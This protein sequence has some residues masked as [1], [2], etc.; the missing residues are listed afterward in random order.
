MDYEV[1][2]TFAFTVAH[3]HVGE[4]LPFQVVV[5]SLAHKSSRPITLSHFQ[6][7]FEGGLRNVDIRHDDHINRQWSTEDELVLFFAPLLQ[8]EDSGFLQG[9]CNLEIAPGTTKVFSLAALPLDAGKIE[10]SK[11]TL[12]VEAEQFG[13][14]LAMSGDNCL[15]QNEVWA[16]DWKGLFRG[17]ILS[18]RSTT[19]EVLPKP[20]KIRIELP[21]IMK[22]YFTGE[23]VSIEV[24][25]IND[26]EEECSVDLEMVLL[27]QADSAPVLHWA[28]TSESTEHA[29]EQNQKSSL[30]TSLGTMNPL[31]TR[32]LTA[33]FQARSE[34]AEGTLEIQAR[35]FLSSDPDTPVSKAISI[36][37]H[38]MRPL[39]A[40]FNFVPQ[41]R[42]E[43]WSS[44]F[45]VDGQIES[46]EN[47]DHE[48]VGPTGFS[49]RWAV[50]AAI[51]SFAS[52]DLVLEA[53]ELQLATTPERA[54]CTISSETGSSSV[55]EILSPHEILERRFILDLQKVGFEDRRTAYF[56]LQLRITWRR[57][58]PDASSA[59]ALLHLPELVI[60][61]GEPRVL[62]S[63]NHQGSSLRTLHL[64]FMIENPSMHVL[65]FS[66][67]MDAGE[68]FAFSGPKSISI[69]LVPYTCHRI[70]YTLLPLV[71]GSWIHPKIKIV[72]I[73]WNKM[74]KV[75]ATGDIR[76]D[77]KGI[78]IWIN[79]EK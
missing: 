56:D 2:A 23:H 75:N 69:Q 4:A 62:A 43:S 44:Y 77:K 39:E 59:I 60:P 1:S 79:P 38:F 76:S 6:L 33:S 64:D 51:A 58:N 48:E 50:T 70:R 31:E 78:A 73:H 68:E 35:Y 15:H 18:E 52:T 28:T 65:S 67:T 9:A 32:R 66:V 55:V 36:D 72:D 3:G 8:K 22:A 74:L 20:P 49:Q 16:A 57:E 19:I 26:E 53:V 41:I 46:A 47:A 37:M 11:I 40:N 61:F 24:L 14:E 10:V 42:K 13:F 54:A 27:D 5:R 17:E 34:T 30:K 7:E 63:V 29:S 25:V 45:H 71:R 21:N 12:C